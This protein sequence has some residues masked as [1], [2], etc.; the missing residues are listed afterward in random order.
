MDPLPSLDIH[1]ANKNEKEPFCLPS[2][3]QATCVFYAEAKSKVICPHK[4]GAVSC[5]FKFKSCHKLYQHKV[6]SYYRLKNT[7]ATI[8][9]HLQDKNW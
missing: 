5:G 4:L 2:E 9:R 8:A 3:K 1:F 7:I 6:S